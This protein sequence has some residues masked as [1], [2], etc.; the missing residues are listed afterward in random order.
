MLRAK[1]SIIDIIAGF[2]IVLDD[3]FSVGDFVEIDGVQGTISAIGLKSTKIKDFTNDNIIVIGNRNIVKALHISEIVDIDIPA[4]YEEDT[5]KMEKIIEGIIKETKAKEKVKEAKY[6][7]INRFDDSAVAYKIRLIVPLDY[8]FEA[9]RNTLRRI[10]I[11]FD[12]ENIAIPYKQ[13]DIHNKK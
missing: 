5:L 6:L 7:G 13:I 10:K 12:K 4:P 2:N 11:T 1:V 9:R 8:R 3:Y